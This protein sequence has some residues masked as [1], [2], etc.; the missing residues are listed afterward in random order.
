MPVISN[1]LLE[2]D[3]EEITKFLP[4]LKSERLD[5]SGKQLA[6]NLVSQIEK[7]NILKPVASY[8]TLWIINIVDDKIYLKGG[9]VITGSLPASLFKSARELVV[10]VF[11][12]GKELDELVEFYSRNKEITKSVLLGEMGNYWLH[13]LSLKVFKM[14]KNVIETKGLFISNPLAPGFSGFEVEEQGKIFQL[15]SGKD[16]GMRLTTG[17]MLYPRNSLSMV[18]GVSDS[19][20]SGTEKSFC[21]YCQN[22]ENCQYS[23]EFS[24]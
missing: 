3:F 12:L 5:S 16:I 20:F 7:N 22:Y 23:H 19:P 11:T 17:F 21:Y 8:E 13:T 10:L 6:Q 9:E 2:I 18:M 24:L 14:I 4:F 15:A 1:I